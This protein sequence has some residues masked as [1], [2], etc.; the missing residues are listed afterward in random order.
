MA[1]SSAVTLPIEDSTLQSSHD[2]YE[3]SECFG[4]YREDKE[5]GN[6]VEWVQ[7]GCGQWIHEECISNTVISSDGTEI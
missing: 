3:C 5:M 2:D 4:M 1:G 7:C 6:G